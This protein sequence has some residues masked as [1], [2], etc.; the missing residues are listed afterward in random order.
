MSG[1]LRTLFNVTTTRERIQGWV[2]PKPVALVNHD[3]LGAL[4][5]RSNE[6]MVLCGMMRPCAVCDLTHVL[7]AKIGVLPRAI[8]RV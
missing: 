7:A 4:T 8:V 3:R 1:L 2:N 6:S 5:L